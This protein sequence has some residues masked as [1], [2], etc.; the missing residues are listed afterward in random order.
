MTTT[1]SD[2][3]GT[4]DPA[5]NIA[6]GRVHIERFDI[7]LGPWLHLAD[8]RQRL[9]NPQFDHIEVVPRGATLGAEIRGVD[10]TNE[11]A[12]EAIED[13]KRALADYKVIYFR[14][15]PV[16]SGQ[17][18]AFA[19]RFG[20]LE[21]HPFI[22]GN[23]EHPELVRFEKGADTGGFENGWHHDVTW[24]EIPSMGALLHAIQVPRT[25]GD[26]LFSDM[27]A[28]YDGLT[29]EWKE[30]IEGLHAIH[31]YMLAFALQ[32]PAEKKAEM[33]K[34]YPLVRHPV[35]RTHPVTGRKLIY[36][37]GYFTSHIEGLEDDESREIIKHLLA[38][39]HILEYQYRVNWENDTI[40]FWD[41]AAV[42]HY[43][44]SDYYPDIRIM[45]RASVAGTRPV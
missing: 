4:S 33:R 17:H 3:A 35:V 19:R 13:I 37:N 36:V 43:A 7:S 28:A 1:E 20:G 45:E 2:I 14:K 10:L 32:V 39:A 26:T 29:G 44:A 24:R 41:N 9:A 25:G 30:R 31:D 18:V 6:P 22:T 15:Q 16:T 12:D 5:G 21:V 34:K 38:Q 40:V 27:G 23:K 11:L 8:E 42:Q